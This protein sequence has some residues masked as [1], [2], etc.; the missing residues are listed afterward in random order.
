MTK[1][2]YVA[3]AIASVAGGITLIRLWVKPEVVYVPVPTPSAAP[4]RPPI[5]QQ[6]FKDQFRPKMPPVDG[7]R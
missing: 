1:L 3:I 7:G 5:H 6:E 4:S 2:L